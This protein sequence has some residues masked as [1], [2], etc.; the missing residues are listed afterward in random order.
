MLVPLSTREVMTDMQ[1]VFY[2]LET[3]ENRGK[4]SVSSATSAGKEG[5][6]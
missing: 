5:A 1:I 6:G 2:L 4:D 3:W